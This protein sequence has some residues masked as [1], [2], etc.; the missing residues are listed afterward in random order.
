MTFIVQQAL[1]AMGPRLATHPRA[2]SRT[3]AHTLLPDGRRIVWKASA[4]NDFGG[5]FSIEI[6][7][8]DGALNDFVANTS[9]PPDQGATYTGHGD[10]DVY[11]LKVDTYG[12]NW[13]ITAQ[14]YQYS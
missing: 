8:S 3:D 6:Y 11:Y 7:N 12:C 2:S 10:L 1:H 4:S 14:V 9:T 5:I 13:G